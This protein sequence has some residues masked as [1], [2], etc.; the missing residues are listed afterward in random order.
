[1]A[2]WLVYGRRIIAI[3]LRSQGHPEYASQACAALSRA[4]TLDPCLLRIKRELSVRL[5]ALKSQDS[6]CFVHWELAALATF[7]GF[8]WPQS[9][10]GE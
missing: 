2:R 9:R 4:K 6:A 7:C 10:W 8:A 1:M 3:A 5:R